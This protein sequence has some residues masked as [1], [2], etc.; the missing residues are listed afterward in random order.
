MDNVYGL[1]S[2][3]FKAGINAG[4]IEAAHHANCLM[5]KQ[6][7]TFEDFI[8]LIAPAISV[9]IDDLKNLKV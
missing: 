2:L 6:P 8:K 1:L 4:I 3:A 9:S 7:G 5:D